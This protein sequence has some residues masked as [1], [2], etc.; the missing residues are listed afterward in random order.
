M[1]DNSAGSAE[2][3]IRETNSA[4]EKRKTAQVAYEQG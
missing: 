1:D 3:L 2:D 4:D